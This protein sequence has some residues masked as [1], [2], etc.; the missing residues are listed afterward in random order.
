MAMKVLGQ[1]APSATSDTVLYTVPAGKATVCS[2]L[3][4]CNRS[5]VSVTYRIAVRPNGAA[6]AN[7]HYIAYD[8]GLAAS[9]SDLWTIGLALAE[10]DVV[11][12]YASTSNLSF[13]MFGDES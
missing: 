12:I 7:S 8:V 11:S 1:V 3:V 9:A 13:S 6:L 4:V 5:A 10:T 2:T